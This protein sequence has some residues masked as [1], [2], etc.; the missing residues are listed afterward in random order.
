MANDT[1]YLTSMAWCIKTRCDEGEPFKIAEFWN[2]VMIPGLDDSGAALRYSYDEALAQVDR[3]SLPAPLDPTELVL[4]RTV[5]ISDP[6]YISFLNSVKAY[7]ASGKN[8][9][10]YSLLVFLSGVIIPI[11]FSFLRFVPFPERLRSKFYAYLIDPPAFGKRHSVAILSLGIVPTRGQALF[12][13]YIVAIN[14]VATFEGYPEFAPNGLYPDRPYEVKRLISDRAG[15]IAF[16]NVPLIILYAGRNSL[17]L[18]LTNWSR[19]TFLLLHRWIATISIFQVILHS[20]IWLQFMVETDS[21]AIAVTYPYWYWGIVGTVAFSLFLPF[22]FLPVRRVLYEVFLIAHICLAVLV[23]VSSWYHIWYLYED[24]SGFEVWLLIAIV[25]WGYE[26]F[27]RML[28]VSRHGIKRA[29]I[30]RVGDGKYLRIDIPGVTAHGHCFVYFPTLTWRVWENH[31]F[32]VVNCSAGQLLGNNTGDSQSSSQSQSDNEGPFLASA[33]A[34]SASKETGNVASNAHVA[35]RKKTRTG[36]TLFIRP[37]SGLT[38]LFANKI[39][40]EAGVPI[41]IEC[42]YGHDDRSRFAPT[43][44]YPNLLVI[45]GGVGITGALPALNSSV[46]MFSRPLGTTKLYWGIKSRGLVDAVKAMIVGEDA[47]GEKSGDN[48]DTNWG[49]IEAHTSIGERMDIR[50]VL[51]DELEHATGGTVVV[52]CGPLAM[53][54]EARYTCAALA[55]HGTKASIKYV[56]ESFSW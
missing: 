32:S 56:E 13:L 51:T 48:A 41:L 42:S 19:S 52:V 40:N 12:I 47:K 10:K 37:Q 39:G 1:A 5:A 54:D 17:L 55:R 25:V 44:E 34:D 14:A 53:C 24:S 9:S 38:K 50:R 8:E 49:H 29:Y 26:R 7:Q 2:K 21:H 18:R 15:V 22:S 6:V 45:A 30:T 35:T 43:P 36:I 28:R 16:A 46:S 23:L 3:K 31:P 4:N 27:L 11:A 33:A 20:L